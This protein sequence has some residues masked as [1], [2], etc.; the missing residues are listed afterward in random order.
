MPAHCVLIT[1]ATNGAASDSGMN[2]ELK[3]KAALAALDEVRPGMRLGL[4][5]GSTAAHFVRGLGMRVR[6]GLSVVCVPTSEATARLAQAEGIPLTVLDDLPDLDLT[7]DGADEIDRKLRL[8]KGGGGALLREKIVAAS[9]RRVI[10]VADASKLVETL[11]AF[12]LPIEAE[13]F[14]LGSTRRRIERIAGRLGL[15]GEL[16]LR[17]EPDGT[18]FVSDGGNA[19][20]DASFGRIPDP[21]ALAA[22]LDGVP[23]VVDHGL[24]LGLASN[25]VIA[26]ETGIEWLGG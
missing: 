14:G 18:L 11:G 16:R 10:I 8:I 9:S 1:R 25:A 7:V 17:R 26:H 19:I 13:R 12:P 5:S 23:G 4:G 3:R 2:D 6:E 15:T 22:A 21:E 24:F 20:I